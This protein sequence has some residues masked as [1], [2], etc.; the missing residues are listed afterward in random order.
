MRRLVDTFKQTADRIVFLDRGYG[1]N[2]PNVQNAIESLVQII[3]EKEDYLIQ[4]IN[5]EIESLVQRI[6]ERE[7]YGVNVRDFGAKGDGVTDDYEA[8]QNALDHGGKI[9]FPRGVYMVSK[10]LKISSNTHIHGDKA[11]IKAMNN[12]SFDTISPHPNQS[13][14]HH[15]Y[16]P[17]VTTKFAG[18]PE[19]YVEN[20][21]V[22]GIIFDWN[23]Q[24]SDG[25]AN[26]ALWVANARNVNIRN[27]E[28]RNVIPSDY[29]LDPIPVNRTAPRTA[30]VLFS[31]VEDCIVS[32]SIFNESSY[33]CLG[34]RYHNRRII[35]T[36]SFFN[37][38]NR[39]RH[40]IEIA[41]LREFNA[42]IPSK[43]T[44]SNNHFVVG[45]NS[46]D[47]ISSHGADNVIVAN[48]TVEILPSA[49]KLQVVMKAFD[50]SQNVTFRGN[51]IDGMNHTLEIGFGAIKADDGKRPSGESFVRNISIINNIVK[52]TWSGITTA[53]HNPGISSEQKY[54]NTLLG[55]STPT[56]SG[57]TENI[58]VSG[59]HITVD[60]YPQNTD[61]NAIAF[62]AVN[63]VV[64]TGNVITF[65]N[66]PSS[67]SNPPKAINLY[68]V[69]SSGQTEPGPNNA[70]VT[71]NVIRRKTASLG[72]VYD[73]STNAIVENNQG[74]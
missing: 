25:Y 58:I 73:T 40:G 18:D 31:Y 38:N 60:G 62:G 52:V 33:E 15:T 54:H 30:G 24:P 9:F 14:K 47:V 37:V 56:S 19:N 7:G 45:G 12:S 10:T 50:G 3:N 59:N 2:Q 17:M 21:L 6:N 68:G 27:I 13:N 1:I 23:N 46:E 16:L 65:Q 4:R 39:W 41:A 72:I 66:G 53:Q 57:T 8:I 44:I 63:G 28:T 70:I 51:L 26:V 49:K 29:P 20:I 11:I 32:D 71:N 67:S 35:V 5:E 22:E 43:I 48:N 42:G 34:I 69:N 74:A 61:L 55:C 36:N 64:C